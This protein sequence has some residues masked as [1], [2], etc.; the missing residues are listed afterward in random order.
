M[1]FQEKLK[2]IIDGWDNRIKSFGV[3]VGI[4]FTTY[5]RE[6][7][8]YT[9]ANDT[10]KNSKPDKKGKSTDFNPALVG[11]AKSKDMFVNSRS[12]KL[13]RS[14]LP[15][16]GSISKVEF[17]QNLKVTIGSE[18]EYAKTQEDGATFIATKK[19]QGLF[20]YNA[21][22]Y[23]SDFFWGMFLH[24]RLNKAFVIPARPYF[25]PSAKKFEQQGIKE[26]GNNFI[27]DLIMALN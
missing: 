11:Y 27:N 7:L 9:D 1:D 13:F 26:I 19:Q 5:L 17:N 21:Q 10:W 3:E 24:A 18:K 23:N 20:L 15:H 25:N 6:A 14:F 22:R 12:G 4:S 8:H 16:K 2:E